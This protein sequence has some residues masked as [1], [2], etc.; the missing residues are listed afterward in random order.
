MDEK[1]IMAPFEAWWAPVGE[2]VPDL[3]DTPSGNWDKIGTNGL[4]HMAEGGVTVRHT[5]TLNEVRTEGGT[6]PQKVT[7]SEE[8]LEVEF[9]IVDMS[10]EEYAKAMNDQTVTDTAA[11]SGTAGVRSI[12]IRRGTDVEVKALLLRGASPYGSSF[13]SQYYVAQAYVKGDIE[14][15]YTKNDKAMVHFL[16]GAIEDPSQAAEE[17]RLAKL[18]MQD[19]A[20]AE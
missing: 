11:G 6:A 10:L 7:R 15:V 19:A 17:D 8:D 9:N 18:Y 12:P 4:S 2:S 5:Q 1:I 3:A 14:I 20:A 13:S 16:F